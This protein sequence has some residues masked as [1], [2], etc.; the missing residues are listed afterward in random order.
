MVK[1]L[2]HSME[3]A[4]EQSTGTEPRRKS[5]TPPVVALALPLALMVP[6]GWFVFHYARDSICTP[7][8]GKEHQGVHVFFFWILTY[9]PFSAVLVN[10]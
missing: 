5:L 1:G 10:C 7:R 9:F 6:Y 3:N 2:H 8:I 4:T